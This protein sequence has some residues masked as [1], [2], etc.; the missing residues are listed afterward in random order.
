METEK[1][2]FD[3]S[4][5]NG[6]PTEELFDKDSLSI[7]YGRISA[8]DGVTVVEL[9][10]LISEMVAGSISEPDLNAYRQGRPPWKKLH[11]EVV[12]VMQFLSARYPGV[13][14]VRFPL[15]DQAPDAW[16]TIDGQTPVG[17]EVTG[18]LSR[19]RVEVSKNMAAKGIVPGFIGL[20]DNATI[21]EF[22]AAKQRGRVAHSAAAV[23]DALE[24]G[25]RKQLES[26]NQT[27]Y[28]GFILIVTANLQSSPSRTEADWNARLVDQAAGLPFSQVFLVDGT[29]G[30]RVFQLK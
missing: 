30:K 8:A 28:E 24:A 12:P 9:K 4:E 29:S 3:G 15:D 2:S 5:G 1:R 25:I 17:I 20:Q 19:S 26:K 16:L 27:K 21:A 11:D 14:R 22:E 6:V 13:A 23:N 18:A 7:L 10:T